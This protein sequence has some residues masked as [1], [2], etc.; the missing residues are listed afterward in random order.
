M[1]EI[2][3]EARFRDDRGGA[4][5]WREAVIMKTQIHLCKSKKAYLISSLL[6]RSSSRRF[7]I[8]LPSGSVL[9]TPR[10]R[11]RLE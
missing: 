2:S 10:P 8:K 6:C 9:V 5:I 4:N 1:E 7:I 11:R 3:V